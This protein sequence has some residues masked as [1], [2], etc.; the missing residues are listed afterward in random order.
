MW[1]YLLARQARKRLGHRG[2]IGR[3]NDEVD[4]QRVQKQHGGRVEVL[5]VQRLMRTR[6]VR[7]YQNT[8]NLP[9]T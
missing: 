4:E 9:Q 5:P 7:S 1:N 8:H 3:L 6:G 2:R